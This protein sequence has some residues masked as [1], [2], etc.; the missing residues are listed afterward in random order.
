MVFTY[1]LTKTF[2][3]AYVSRS[4]WIDHHGE[5]TT[6][7]VVSHVL[8]HPDIWFVIIFH[9]VNHNNT[10]DTE[11]Q[12]YRPSQDLLAYMDEDELSMEESKKLA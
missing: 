7:D 4:I 5:L 11:L 1:I 8:S 6:A 10:I 3:A 9:L 12:D 2:F